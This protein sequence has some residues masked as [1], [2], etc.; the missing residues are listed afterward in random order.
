M[1]DNFA[2]KSVSLIL[3]KGWKNILKSTENKLLLLIIIHLDNISTQEVKYR[4]TCFSE[5]DSSSKFVCACSLRMDVFSWSCHFV[6]I[7]ILGTPAV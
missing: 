2:K 3:K 7:S 6:L 4:I 1:N 5:S